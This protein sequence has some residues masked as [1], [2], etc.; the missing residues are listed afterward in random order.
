[1]LLQYE[2]EVAQAG[3]AKN[4]GQIGLFSLEPV[5]NF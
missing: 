4:A 1:M 5:M 3:L 2:Q